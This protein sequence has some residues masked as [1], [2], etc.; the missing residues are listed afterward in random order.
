MIFI[1]SL[2][3]LNVFTILCL[4]KI[5]QSVKVYIFTGYRESAFAYAISSAGVAH[6]VAR[7]CSQGRLISCG[8][9][10]SSYRQRDK[11]S[12]KINNAA[13]WKWR[14]CSHNL[15]FGFEFSKMFLDSREKAGDIHSKISL[16]NNQAGR[17]VSFF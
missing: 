4:H 13:L 11:K 12:S 17:L 15:H 10:P 2:L 9:D 8:C 7:A 5:I 1:K 6:S 16:H 14:G 3:K